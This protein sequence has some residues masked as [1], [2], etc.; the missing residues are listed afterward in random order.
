MASF[1]HKWG[2]RGDGEAERE[3][4]ERR[5]GDVI[6]KDA[7]VGSWK[8]GKCTSLHFAALLHKFLK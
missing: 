5:F 2:C 6:F 7:E 3:R 8:G 4:R 1:P